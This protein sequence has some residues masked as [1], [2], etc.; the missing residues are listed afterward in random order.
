MPAPR[1]AEMVRELQAAGVPYEPDITWPVAVR[2]QSALYVA[3]GYLCERR[4]ERGA[5]AK[6]VLWALGW[7]W[8]IGARSVYA[9]WFRS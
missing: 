6:E 4:E 2:Q 8:A 9:E 5:L 1:F 3:L 7:I